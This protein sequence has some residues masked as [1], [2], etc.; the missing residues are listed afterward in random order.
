M[1]PPSKAWTRKPGYHPQDQGVVTWGTMGWSRGGLGY[2]THLSVVLLVVRKVVWDLG[3][4]ESISGEQRVE[5]VANT[6]SRA[7]HGDSKMY[8]A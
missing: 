6:N 4:N 5:P 1:S 3:N 2:L 8:E 7:G